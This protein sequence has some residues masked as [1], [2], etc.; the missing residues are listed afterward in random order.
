[1]QFDIDRC[2]CPECSLISAST[3]KLKQQMS[4]NTCFRRQQEIRD[5]GIEASDLYS[6]EP[7]EFFT[8]EF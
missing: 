8:C 1:M 2:T 3:G 6:P 5:R 4:K 7:S